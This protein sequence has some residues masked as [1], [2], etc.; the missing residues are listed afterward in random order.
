MTKIWLKFG[1][2]NLSFLHCS[3]PNVCVWLSL[4]TSVILDLYLSI[5]FRCLP[6]IKRSSSL[7]R[8]SE[9]TASSLVEEREGVELEAGLGTG[10]EAGLDAGVP[11]WEIG[12]D[13]GWGESRDGS[14][15]V[16]ESFV[17]ILGLLNWWVEPSGLGVWFS[18]SSGLV[19][20]LSTLLCIFSDELSSFWDWDKCSEAS[21]WPTRSLSLLSEGEGGWRSFCVCGANLCNRK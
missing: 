10:T 9:T 1:H 20:L 16:A 21:D 19:S 17:S 15:G 14:E 11:S 3:V 8:L 12:M 4:C 7:V 2:K 5:A 18:C 13:N 6:T